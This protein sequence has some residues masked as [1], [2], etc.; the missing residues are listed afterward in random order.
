MI[1]DPLHPA[2]VHF[3][4]ALAALVPM[5]AFAAFAAVWLG[6]LPGRIWLAVVLLHGMLAGFAWFA[7]E[8]GEDQEERVEKVVSERFIHEHEE[9][10][11]RLRNLAAV[12]FVVSAIGLLGGRAGSIGRVAT[13]AAGLVVMAASIPA[14]RTGGA[15]V[16]EHGAADAYVERAAP[17]QTDREQGGD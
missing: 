4:V 14:G 15:L 7:V 16:Y 6:W 9:A 3:P 1:P 10:A 11:E 12:A 17:A 13:L 8:T 5:A 2:I